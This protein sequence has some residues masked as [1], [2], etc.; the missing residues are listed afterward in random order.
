MHLSK[1]QAQSLAFQIMEAG[2]RIGPE[3]IEV[4]RI[5]RSAGRRNAAVQIKV[6]KTPERRSHE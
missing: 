2:D 5:P 6:F 4:R 1:S 3:G